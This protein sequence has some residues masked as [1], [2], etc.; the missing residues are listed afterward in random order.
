MKQILYSLILFSAVF[1]N[2][3]AKNIDSLHN[4]FEQS[5]QLDS[6]YYNTFNKLT[7]HFIK[8]KSDSCLYYVDKLIK[9]YPDSAFQVAMAFRKKAVYFKSVNRDSSYFYI[10]K[11]LKEVKNIKNSFRKWKMFYMCYDLFSLN[12]KKEKN[13]YESLR[14]IDSS[15]KYVTLCKQNSPE[16]IYK[17]HSLVFMYRYAYILDDQEKSNEALNYCQLILDS[18]R[19]LDSSHPDHKK[20]EKSTY[21]MIGFIFQ[22]QQ[23]Y[24]SALN[25]F[26]KSYDMVKDQSYLIDKVIPLHNIAENH[27][28]KENFKTGLKILNEVKTMV[29]SLKSNPTPL[30]YT[31][32][33]AYDSLHQ[34]QIALEYYLKFYKESK[35]SD[36]IS[37]IEKAAKALYLTYKKIN[38][39]KEALSYYKEHIALR[40]SID[41][42]KASEETLQR[43]LQ[44]KYELKV[45]EDSIKNIER[46]KLNESQLALSETK[47]KD[48]KNLIIGVLIVLTLL[49]LFSIIVY[50]RYKE[51]VKQKQ[52][53]A[54]Q[55]EQVDI[56]FNQLDEKKVE[57]EKKNTE[58]MDSINY[59]KYIQKALLPSQES[60]ESFFENQ[61]I[62][63]LPKD[64]VGGDFYCFKSIGDQAVIVA[65]DCTGHGVPGGFGTMIGSLVIEKS[66]KKGLKDPNQIL[67][68]LNYGIVTLLK[69]YKDDS[70]QDGM[71]IS[72]CLVD[73][74]TKKVKF[75]GSRNGIHIVD[76]EEIHSI[77]GDLTPVGGYAASHEESK[78]RSYQLHEI[79]LKDNQWIFMYSDG[80]YDQFGGPRNK[81]M[82][83]SRFKGIIQEAV[84]MNK[85]NAPDFKNYF[86]DWMG[87]EEQIDDVLVIGFKL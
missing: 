32:A 17:I 76:S 41:E 79:E 52:I 84:T 36:N 4:V 34:D 42:M 49:L 54:E 6:S 37:G 69:Q 18:I 67:T 31:Y 3:Y 82:G 35:E 60:I 21:G 10:E 87:D 9:D 53:I 78:N 65:G 7:T 30:Y 46:E 40:D 47:I 62:F 14:F 56:A 13:F 85:T 28:L 70:I 80:F 12:K 50:F 8:S 23:E 27:I 29:D 57:L 55:K 75:S 63:Y 48:T 77:K 15:L 22:K 5:E 61:F 43:E 64:I 81:S 1:S 16:Y 45:Q 51:S 73:K 68:D 19:V 83:S 59:A 11:S 74:K 20:I 72:I 25:Y 39:S 26:Q 86:F 44:R 58:I 71:D 66:L 33:R 2:T 38:N 24:D